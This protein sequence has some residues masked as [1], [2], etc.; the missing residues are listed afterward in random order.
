MTQTQVENLPLGVFLADNPRNTVTGGWLSIN[1][2]AASRIDDV[3][4]LPHGVIVITSQDPLVFSRLSA[5][6]NLRPP[7]FLGRNPSA[8]ASDLG[9][10]TKWGERDPKQVCESSSSIFKKT[11]DLISGI[12]PWR[13][14]RPF[15]KNT[16]VEDIQNLL[17]I[18]AMSNA[19]PAIEPSAFVSAYQS[20]SL[21]YGLNRYEDS[22]HEF[23]T[24]RRNQL[25]HCRYLCSC[26]IPNGPKWE[27][28]TAQQMGSDDY[29]RIDFALNADFPLLLEVEITEF[30]DD[31]MARL[32]SFGS[33]VNNTSIKAAT[34]RTHVTDV[35]LNWLSRF[36]S[37]RILSGLKTAK[38]LPLPSILSFPKPLESDE[39]LQ[40][41]YSAGLASF[42]HYQAIGEKIFT[43]VVR[44]NGEKYSYS[45]RNV[46]LK[47]Y[48]RAEMFV[49]AL[50]AHRKGFCVMGYGSGGLRLAY[51]KDEIPYIMEFA[52]EQ[53]FFAPNF[54]KLDQIL[55][56]QELRFYPAV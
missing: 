5:I 51:K 36:A 27:K 28:L 39:L 50:R 21:V 30:Q 38:Y 17:G 18:T 34:V 24:L 31:E 23:L 22:E 49:Y 25:D 32:V 37:V 4:R 8:I 33:S 56:E 41:S 47:A 29:Q 3:A 11:I 48:D 6:K 16:V 43:R 2:G 1:G 53:G 55:D 13:T 14:P 19:T 52:I 9:I 10:P 46:W 45:P 20:D 44:N 54:H 42:I 12:Y 15:T 26:P 40:L 7:F 35:E